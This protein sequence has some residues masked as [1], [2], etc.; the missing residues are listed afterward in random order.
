MKGNATEAE[1]EEE[2]T[3]GTRVGPRQDV[4]ICPCT[5][6]SSQTPH[7]KDWAVSDPFDIGCVWRL[8]LH[9][10]FPSFCTHC[11]HMQILICIIISQV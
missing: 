1:E 10:L 6:S 5:A 9:T 8:S 11:S 2:D 7:G 3:E 4:W